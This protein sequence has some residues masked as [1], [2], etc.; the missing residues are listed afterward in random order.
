MAI[1]IKTGSGPNDWATVSPQIKTGSGPNDWTNVNKGEIY[2]GSGWSTFYQ[3]FSGTV[4]TPTITLSS[5]T[6]N[7]I[8]VQVTLPTGSPYKT[9]VTVYR[10][11][12]ALGA[13]NIPASPAIGSISG[14]K[15]ETGLS[16]NTSYSFS[17]YA[18][19]Y[20]PT[21][22]E[23]LQQSAT[24][25]ETFSTLAY[26]ITT[27]T[28]PVNSFRSTSSLSFQ[29][30]SNAN[31]STN[32]SAAYIEFEFYQLDIFLGW[33]YYT[34]LNRNLTN[35]DSD[36]TLTATITSLSMGSTFRCRARTVYSSINETSPWS[37][38]STAATTQQ[39]V[40]SYIPSSST[41]AAAN[42]S[43]HFSNYATSG[44]SFKDA[45]K[46]YSNGSDGDTGTE[47][48]SNP[49]TTSTVN[50]NETRTINRLSAT[51][52]FG[53]VVFYTT[54]AAHNL[55]NGTYS[56]SGVTIS[57]LIYSIVFIE[58][59]TGFVFVTLPSS[60]PGALSGTFTVNGCSD[61]RFNTSYTIDTYTTLGDGNKRI[62]AVRPSSIPSGLVPSSPKGSA[63]MSGAANGVSIGLLGGGALESPIYTDNNTTF[64][65]FD[66]H[67][68]DISDTAA[69][70]SVTYTVSS[71]QQV[72]K[73]SPNDEILR[74]A[75]QPNLPSGATNVQ[76]EAIQTRCGGVASPRIVIEVNGGV[77]TRTLSSGLS[78]NTAD[79]WT[80]PSGIQPNT[81][82]LGVSNCWYI[83]LIVRSGTS[84][85]LLYS[86][87]SEVQIRYSYQSLN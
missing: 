32:A 35:N 87:I 45:N 30:T 60:A 19:Y 63:L 48:M 65:R 64:R 77:A 75:F 44:S 9:Q 61:S 56:Y 10:T 11:S 24:V 71:Q 59:T 42:N 14:F 20:D 62:R 21:T 86:T 83:A 81:T 16:A 23:V 73:T 47:W 13:S 3:R 85:S 74:L 17:A 28:T 66:A 80:V 46:V 49:Y 72:P 67:A 34:T 2:T 29:S 78:A 57:S 38:Y 40:T 27:P 5:R 70:G 15:T 39:Y 33:Q 53:G 84:G 76:L 69:S 8:T 41:F 36:Q 82:N 37:S 51:T 31:Y 22:N 6:V 26:V 18:L 58:S 50:T 7:S 12:N 1:Q 4:N 25:T 52:G 43:T 79:I 54:S 55:T 68:T